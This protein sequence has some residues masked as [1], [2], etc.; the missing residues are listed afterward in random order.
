MSRKHETATA[1]VPLVGTG[2]YPARP[3][4]RLRPLVDG[5]P[6][7][8]R[9]CDAVD[10]AQHSVW[11]TVAFLWPD[12]DMPDGRGSFF[13]ILDRA[14]TRGADVR[15]IFWRPNDEMAHHRPN[16]F[17]GSAEHLAVLA[18]RRPGL[19]IRWDRA[20]PGFAQHQKSWLIDAGEAGETA[21]VGGI[22]LNP[23]SVVAPGHR[24]GE[25]NHDIYLELAGPAAVDVHHNFVQRWNEASERYAP[26]GRW[27]AGAETDLVFPHRVPPPRGE[28]LA[29][30]QRTIGP[31]RY[32]DGPATPGGEPFPIVD[33]EWSIFEQYCAA[34]AAAKRS[35][36][37]ENQSLD[38]VEIIEALGAAL[39]RGVAVL[40][41]VPGEPNPGMLTPSDPDQRAL[42]A[43]RTALQAYPNFTL[44]A[45]AGLGADGLR[46]HVFVHAKIMLV[47]DRWATIGSAN[48]HRRSQFGHGE[49]NVSFWDER[50]VRTLRRD[51]LHDHLDMDT[52]ALD[53]R[54]ALQCFR[55]VAHENR[56]K[57]EAGNHSW[58]GLAFA[59]DASSYGLTPI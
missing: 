50:A 20:N 44:A 27:G 7:F 19:K 51:L 10:A 39:K 11:V 32:S 29:Q 14:A 15:V 34:I 49:M 55:Q 35:V 28:S 36:Y 18:S 22:N 41:V 58:Q 5:Q 4:N 6:A 57:W 53:D 38:V 30:V 43:A 59:L 37:I 24:G 26:D 16:A 46:K 25:N 17:W 2:S 40:A 8:R 21:F 1:V 3:G 48:L 56:A 9:I 12:F 13:D 31:G 47:D 45:L 33:G 54:A 42:I 52:G 23:R